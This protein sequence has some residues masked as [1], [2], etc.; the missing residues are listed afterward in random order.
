MAGRYACHVARVWGV[1]LVA[2]LRMGSGMGRVGKVGGVRWEWT[3]LAGYVGAGRS[4]RGPNVLYLLHC[5][6]M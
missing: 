1:G 2:Q 3:K 4:E 5:S 6:A